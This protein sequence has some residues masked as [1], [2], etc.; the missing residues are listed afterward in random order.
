MTEIPDQAAKV[1]GILVDGAQDHV[2]SAA[3]QPAHALAA[4]SPT[5]ATGVIVINR[6][7]LVL[8]DAAGSTRAALIS[9]HA[10]VVLLS[11]A[12]LGQVGAANA[13]GTQPVSSA[14]PGAEGVLRKPLV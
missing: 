3:Q 12:E 8:D 13:P 10:S 9:Q 14:L 2:T 7:G 5:A 1:V 11:K 4:R 6:K